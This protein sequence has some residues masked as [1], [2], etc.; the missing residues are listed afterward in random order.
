M[1][2]RNI[3]TQ[4]VHDLVIQTAYNSLDKINHKVYINPNQEKNTSIDNI[5]YP[6]II[7]T[8]LN[9]SNVKFIIEVETEDSVI[10]SEVEQWKTYSKLCNSFYLLVPSNVRILA[11]Q[12]C[13]QNDI[14]V[15]F[16][17]YRFENG[18]YLIKYE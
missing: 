3:N 12:I 6:D 2:E 13:V 17:T 8:E 5:H 4:N 7:I 16:G 11:E 18:N 14:K 15:R 9:N 1:A 10:E